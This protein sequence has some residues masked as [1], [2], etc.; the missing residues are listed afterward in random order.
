MDYGIFN[1]RTD[2]NA[3]DCTRRC[4]DTERESALK[5][6]SGR[7]IPC[8]IG[9]SKL[10]QRRDGPM[11]LLWAHGNLFWQLSGDGNSSG[12]VMSS[13]MTAFPKPSFRAP[14]RNLALRAESGRKIPCRTGEWNPRQQR[15]GPALYQLSYIPSQKLLSFL[16]RQDLWKFSAAKAT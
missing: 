16:Q 14:R 2:V 5:V 7:K 4:P 6:G 8:R 13:A 1:V 12:S 11:L 15:A 10:R 9:K 3:W